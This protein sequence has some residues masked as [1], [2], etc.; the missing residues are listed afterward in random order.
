MIADPGSH[1]LLFE[2]GEFRIIE[3][4]IAPG[5]SQPVHTHRGKTLAWTVR[6]SQVVQTGYQKSSNNK[7]IP[8]KKDTINF[9]SEDLNKA[10]WEASTPPHAMQNIGL[11]TFKQYRI[12]Y[13]N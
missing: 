12:E 7:W 3:V 1:R 11:D 10:N 9:S 5:Q 6:S 2:N 13:K 8:V 4:T